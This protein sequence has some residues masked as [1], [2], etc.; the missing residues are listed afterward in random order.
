MKVDFDRS[1]TIYLLDFCMISS[2]WYCIYLSLHLSVRIWIISFSTSSRL[3]MATCH[4]LV[5]IGMPICSFDTRR[6]LSCW[7]IC[8]TFHFYKVWRLLDHWLFM[9]SNL[10]LF[11]WAHF[12]VVVNS[13]RWTCQRCTTLLTLATNLFILNVVIHLFIRTLHLIHL[14]L[15]VILIL[16]S[17]CMV[18]SCKVC[19]FDGDILIFIN[20]LDWLLLR[21]DCM[22]LCCIWSHLLFLSLLTR[23]LLLNRDSHLRLSSHLVSLLICNAIMCYSSHLIIWRYS[24]THILS[25]NV[26]LS[27]E[28]FTS[29]LP[30]VFLR[31]V[32]ERHLVEWASW[33]GNNG[34]IVAT[35]VSTLV[36]AG[37]VCVTRFGLH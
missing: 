13:R 11:H 31:T 10:I 15:S 25:L 14:G 3:E 33:I 20:K 35:L 21:I 26:C 19:I 17:H 4:F 18:N 36:A 1:V 7:I 37:L 29:Q 34:V 32:G 6:T 24:M 22:H 27:I 2:W 8:L 28:I 9:W 12:L 5:M 23:R 16:I 30:D